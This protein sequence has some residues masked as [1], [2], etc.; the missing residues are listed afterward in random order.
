MIN[1]HCL[2]NIADQGLAELSADRF[3]LVSDIEQADA[4]ILRSS[5]LHGRTL[6]PRIRAVARAGVGTDNIPVDPLSHLGVPVF[7]APGANANAVKELVLASM[8]MGYRHLDAAREFLTKLPVDD[9]TALQQQIEQNK[10]QFSGQEIAGKTLGVIGLGNIGVKL[11]NAAF[12]L[13]M[14]V[15]A[16]DPDIRL[17]SALALMPGIKKVERM[18]QMLP[19]VDVLSLHIP[20]LKQTQALINP[21]SCA[22]LQKNAMV[23]NFSRAGIV[24]D[25][26]ILQA[27]DS[28]HLRLYITDFP[29][30]SLRQHPKVLAFPHVGASTREAEENCARL[31]CRNLQDF[32]LYGHIQQSINFPTISLPRARDSS[33]VRYFIAN[34]NT[35]GIIAHLSQAISDSGYNIEQMINQSQGDIACNLIDV[36]APFSQQQRI[37]SSLLAIDGVLRVSSLPLSAG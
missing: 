28:Q 20:L 7:F 8:I 25:S 17:E 15:I 34:T 18:E 31:V 27:L 26:A 1:L 14:Q 6:S 4:L 10:K 22:T 37:S 29:S 12:A 9:E 16:Y 19:Q 13:G 33:T 35:P 32:M 21:E 5:S 30:L 24:D 11:A 2:D 23:I 3:R 36:S